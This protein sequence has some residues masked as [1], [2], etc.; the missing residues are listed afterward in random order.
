MPLPRSAI[1]LV[2]PALVFYYSRC[3]MQAPAENSFRRVVQAA[4]PLAQGVANFESIMEELKLTLRDEHCCYSRVHTSSAHAAVMLLL[5]AAPVAQ[6]SHAGTN[7]PH[8]SV[9]S[10]A[11]A[12]QAAM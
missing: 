10:A 9:V 3:I 6:P 5:D 8:H 7:H 1:I 12:Q 2:A 4:A 11:A